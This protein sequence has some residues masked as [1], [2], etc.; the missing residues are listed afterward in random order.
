MMEGPTQRQA[1]T[2]NTIGGHWLLGEQ[3]DGMMPLDFEGEK[4]FLDKNGWP[5]LGIRLA[6][7]R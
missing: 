1:C 5:K 3:F 7:Q 6:G 4:K 2:Q